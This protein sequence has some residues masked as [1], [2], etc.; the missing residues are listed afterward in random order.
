MLEDYF[1]EAS[2][3]KINGGEVMI[4]VVLEHK[5][6]DEEHA[7]KLIEA[8][9]QV[10]AE[11]CRQHGFISGNTLVNVH[12]PFHIVVVSSW[13]KLDDWKVWDESRIRKEMLPLIEDNLA[14]PYTAVSI[15]ENVI[16]NEE[17]AHV[18]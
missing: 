8:I 11:A 1:K 17:I 18:F 16:W 9:D 10:R 7:R 6:R 12:D 14:E 3:M 13:Q 2:D 5:A 15:T 4:R